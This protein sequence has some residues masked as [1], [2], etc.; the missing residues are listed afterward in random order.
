MRHLREFARGCVGAVKHTAFSRNIFV[1]FRPE[2]EILYY[3]EA[4]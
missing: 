2:K 3:N 1:N 4:I